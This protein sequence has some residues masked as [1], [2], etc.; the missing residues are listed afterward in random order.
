MPTTRPS[1]TSVGDVQQVYDL[2]TNV[3]ANKAVIDLADL[4]ATQMTL[5][6][7][8]L[9]KLKGFSLSYVMFKEISLLCDISTGVPRP[10]VPTEFRL[11]VFLSIHNLSYVGTRAMR[12]MLTRRWVWKGMQGDVSRW[13]KE[14]VPCQVSKV[15]KHTVPELRE[16]LVPSNG[17]PRLTATLW[18]PCPPR[19]GSATC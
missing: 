12:R 15:T 5:D 13:C 6:A 11:H 9:S 18:G 4:Q 1:V 19:K 10:V 3:P 14:C 17:S 16:I 7:T 2:S 8:Q